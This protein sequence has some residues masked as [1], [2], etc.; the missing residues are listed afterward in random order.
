MKATRTTRFPSHTKSGPGR[1][2]AQGDGTHSHL[3]LKQ[4]SAGAFGRGLRNWITQ[5]N[6]KNAL[7]KAM[8]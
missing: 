5:T 2:H 6:R 4:R 3:T 1:R 8:V 7:A